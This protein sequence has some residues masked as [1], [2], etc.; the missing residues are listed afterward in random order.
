MTVMTDIPDSPLPSAAPARE[1]RWP[2]SLMA[3]LRAN[4]FATIPSTIVTL[5]L[6]FVLG[7]GLVV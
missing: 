3:W 7:K 1:R 6:F 4:L 2:A 5:L